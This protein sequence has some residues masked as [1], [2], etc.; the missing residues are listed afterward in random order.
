MGIRFS[1]DSGCLNT[2]ITDSTM[3]ISNLSGSGTTC[4]AFYGPANLSGT[5]NIT[6]QRIWYRKNGNSIERN[7]VDVPLATRE[8]APES[9][10]PTG[11]WEKMTAPEVEITNLKFYVRGSAL[12]DDQPAVTILMQGIAHVSRTA[13]NFTV[14]TTIT[15][16]TPNSSL[17]KP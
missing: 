12:N 6:T 10:T 7:V 3:N 17:V 9:P 15:P 1:A 2:A 4:L 8:A 13:R 5:S 14:Q 11:T 16:R